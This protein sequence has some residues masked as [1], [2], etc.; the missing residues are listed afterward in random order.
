MTRLKPCDAV[1]LYAGLKTALRCYHEMTM[2]LGL[3]VVGDSV[4]EIDPLLGQVC[5]GI[6]FLWLLGMLS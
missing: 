3:L 4:M 1:V 6:R 5:L 2:P